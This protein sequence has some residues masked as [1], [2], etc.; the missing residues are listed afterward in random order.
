MLASVPGASAGATWPPCKDPALLPH[1]GTPTEG[2]ALLGWGALL[3]LM[4]AL[5]VAW[6]WAH[7]GHCMC[8]GGEGPWRKWG[9]QNLPLVVTVGSLLAMSGKEN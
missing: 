3:E 5:R 9:A 8:G 4:G 1:S 2:A 7:T 6:G